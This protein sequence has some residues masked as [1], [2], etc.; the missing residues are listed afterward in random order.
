M[1]SIDIWHKISSSNMRQTIFLE[2]G[3]TPSLGSGKNF[4]LNFLLGGSIKGDCSW[5]GWLLGAELT[6]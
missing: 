4:G 3:S 2:R 6:Q 1:I 5:H